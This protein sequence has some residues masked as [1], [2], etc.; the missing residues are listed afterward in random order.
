MELQAPQL[1]SHLQLLQMGADEGA[2]GRQGDGLSPQA[3]RAMVKHVGK[4][5]TVVASAL[6]WPLSAVIQRL[7]ASAAQWVRTS[8]YGSNP[9]CTTHCLCDRDK[10]LNLPKPQFTHL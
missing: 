4:E 2:D 1:L 7:G 9:D 3:S 8:G 5:H 10:S 6:L